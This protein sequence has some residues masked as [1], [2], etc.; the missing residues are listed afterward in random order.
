MFTGI[1]EETGKISK[2]QPNKGGQLLEIMASTI[3]P[4]T[5]IG[6]SIAIN[7]VCQTVTKIDSKSFQVFASK[8]TT[9]LTTLGSLNTKQSVNLERALLPTTRLGGHLVQ[10]HVDGQ[11]KI[12]KI[13]KEQGSLEIEIVIP[14]DLKK[15]LIAKGSVAIDGISLTIVSLTSEGFLIYLVPE[16]VNSTIA[17]NWQANDKVNI[18][19]D[20]L[21]KYT[22]KM[23]TTLPQA[24]QKLS[25]QNL[26]EKLFQ[27]G[28]L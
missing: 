27:E 7:G 15:Y 8:I 14:L 23:L 28:F 19:V 13:K 21:A 9:S 6:D 5:K 22:E 18:E 10:G 20:L 17:K 16:T 26:K 24:K 25:D 4:G 11:G 12:K 1:I 2:N 3:I